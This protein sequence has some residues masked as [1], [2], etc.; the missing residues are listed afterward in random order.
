MCYA[1]DVVY[2]FLMRSYMCSRHSY[3]EERERRWREPSAT[4]AIP[5]L[6]PFPHAPAATSPILPPPYHGESVSLFPSAPQ[7]RSPA[8]TP[9]AATTLDDASSSSSCQPAIGEHGSQRQGGGLPR[10]SSRSATGT[11][12]TPAQLSELDRAFAKTHYPDIF[13]REDWLWG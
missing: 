4:V 2:A 3:G 1:S 11:R 13:M 9:A 8:P 10:W 12:F 7:E 5:L 6:P